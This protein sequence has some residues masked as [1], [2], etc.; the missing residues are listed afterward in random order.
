MANGQPVV[1][2]GRFEKAFDGR[3]KPSRGCFRGGSV[4][5]F[6][7]GSVCKTRPRSTKRRIA[8]DLDL[9]PSRLAQASTA[10]LISS[11]SRMAKTSAV[12]FPIRGRPSFF[13]RIT[14]LDDMRKLYYKIKAAAQGSEM[15]S[16]T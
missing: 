10:F 16:A 9:I 4:C 15:P 6:R 14:L 1:S 2:S 13:F 5:K 12:F 8:A 7:G 11:G 3:W